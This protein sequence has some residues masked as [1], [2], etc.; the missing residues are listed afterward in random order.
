MS[1]VLRARFYGVRQRVCAAT[2][3]EGDK[4]IGELNVRTSRQGAIGIFPTAPACTIGE[5]EPPLNN[6]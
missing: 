4:L 6:V 2:N 5:I 3:A 1:A